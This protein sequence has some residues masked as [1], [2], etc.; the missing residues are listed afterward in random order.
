M[1]TELWDN[2]ALQLDT[3]EET[4]SS[5]G[6]SAALAKIDA[7]I[8]S[9]KASDSLNQKQVDILCLKVITCLERSPYNTRVKSTGFKLISDTLQLKFDT[10]SV[11][12]C[13]FLA[14]SSDL[15]A[16][17]ADEFVL[18]ELS[19][20]IA[21]K[22]SAS[23]NLDSFYTLLVPT[24]VKLSA[25]VFQQFQ[26]GSNHHKKRALA[27]VN[28]LLRSFYTVEADVD[29]TTK[30][31]CNKKLPLAGV[32]S[33]IGSL[34]SL[35]AL[36]TLE[37]VKFFVKDCLVP[38]SGITA[39]S[40]Q[41]L[42]PF[43][44]TLGAAEFTELLAGLQKAALRDS[45][46]VY[47]YVSPA[48]FHAIVGFDVI[49]S[50]VA[51]KFFSPLIAALKSSKDTT[52][53]GAYRT[54]NQ[55]VTKYTPGD[56][57]AAL[58][59]LVDELLKVYKTLSNTA[60]EQKVYITT[61]LR[62]VPDGVLN[63]KIVNALLTAAAK[64][65]HQASLSSNLATLYGRF[66]YDL[67]HDSDGDFTKVK[68][69]TLKGLQDKKQ[70]VRAT[71]CT[72]FYGAMQ[73]SGPYSSKFDPVAEAVT[74][75]TQSI[76]TECIKSP[77]PSVNNKLIT[78]GYAAIAL[79]Y[80]TGKL[81]D[82]IVSSVFE[83][84]IL[85]D[86]SL[87]QKLDSFEWFIYAVE[88]VGSIISEDNIGP[89][90]AAFYAGVSKSIKHSH[91]LAY[92]RLHIAYS[93]NQAHLSGSC[94][95]A[96]NDYIIAPSND[97]VISPH[98]LYAFL[99]SITKPF[100]GSDRSILENTLVGLLLPC[101]HES[102][103]SIP[104]GWVAICQ[105]V[106]VDPGQLISSRSEE[107]VDMLNELLLEKDIDNGVYQAA[108]SAISTISF[109]ASDTAVPRIADTIDT[110]LSS[111]SELDV[112][113]EKCAIWLANEG[114]L[115][116]D[117]LSKGEKPQLSKNSKDYETAKWEQEVRKEIAS[118][119]KST[120]SLTKDEKRM[121]AE[122]LKLETE[123]RAS[124]ESSYRKLSRALNLIIALSNEGAKVDNDAKIWFPVAVRQLLVVLRSHEAK[125]LVGD[126][127]TKC[128]LAMAQVL[129]VT[130]L[131]GTS[132]M[133][134]IGASTLRLHGIEAFL[135][136]KYLSIDLKSL[137]NDQLFSLKIAS[138]KSQFS[139]LTMTYILPLLVKVITNGRDFVSKSKKKVVQLD[140]DYIDESPEEE[141]LAL[142]LSI[143][144]SNYETFEDSSIPRT[145]ILRDIIAL[146][147][148][149]SKAK[150][151]KDAF[152]SLCQS[153]AL[154]ISSADLEEIFNACLDPSDYVRTAA[155]ESLDREFELSEL[156][157]VP[158]IWIATFD[159]KQDNRELAQ[160]IWEESKFALDSSVPDKLISYLSHDSSVTRLSVAQSLGDAMAEL[161]D[162][163]SSVID[164]LLDLYRVKA[165]PPAPLK[166]AFG[167]VIKT[168]V[169]TDYWEER[170]GVALSLKY[171]APQFSSSK[172]VEKVFK[173][174][175]EE[176]ALADKNE[177]VCHELKDAGMEIIN[178]HGNENVEALITILE[179][180]LN[181]KTGNHEVDDRMKESTIV[182]Y[183]NLAH[184]LKKGDPRVENIV[185]KLLDALSTP[186]EDVQFA[187]SERIAPLVPFVESHLA[188]HYDALFEKLF[189][190]KT[191]A[192]RRGAAY[193]IAGLTKG[194][195]LIAMTDYDVVRNLE[196]GSDDRSDPKKREGVMFAIE[197]LS[198][199]LG[200]IFEPYVLELLP[201]VLKSFGDSSAEVREAT[202]YAAKEIM[203]NTTS[204]GIKKLIPMAIEN[205]DD[206]AWRAKKGSVELLGSMA[207]LD[208]AQLS[209]SLPTIVPEIVG[210][211]NDSHREVRKAADQ[212]LKKFGEVI[213]NPEI[214]EI[215]PTLL[216]AIG[217]PTK[218][219]DT[220]L[221][222][223]INTQ[224][225][226][227]IDGPSMALIIHVIDR[228]MHDRSAA[229]KKK[230]CQIVGNMAILVDTKDLLA[231]LPKLITEL[232]K[233]IVDPVPQTRTT[234]SRALG[235]L[236]EKLG[237]EQFPTLIPGLLDTLRDPSRPGDRMGSAQALAEIIKGIGP[238]KLDE[239]L[240]II[241]EGTSSPQSH[242]RAGFLPM[243]IFLPACF[244]I[245]Y[246]PYLSKSI[247]PILG[248][249]ADPYDD[250]R[251]VA[252]K[253]GRLIVNNYANKAID[254]L[255]PELEK[256]MAND[257]PRIRLSSV[258]LTGDLLFKISGISGNV[259]SDEE[260]V[261]VTGATNTFNEV[262][263]EE[264]R[265]QVLASLFICRSDSAG[266]VRVGATNIW[267]A[268]VAN[269]PRT[270]KEVL[271]V[272][273]QLIVRRLASSEEA[274]RTIGAAA[275]G[276]MVRRVGGDA[277]S[278]LLPTLEQS[279]VSSDSDAK[280]GICIALR[281]LIESSEPATI[282]EHKATVVKVV[283]SALTDANPS[284]REAAAQV[285]DV[286][287]TSIGNDAVDD[288]IP[289]L[290]EKLEDGDQSDD[291][292]SAL[293][294][295]MS[296]KADVIF[297]ILI[298]TLLKPPINAHAL[299]ALAQVAGPALYRKLS[300]I[301]GSIVR[302]ILEGG[303]REELLSALTN[304]IL[305]VESD[306]GCHSVML[307]ILAL[308]RNEDDAKV[309]VIYEVLPQ[310]I[311]ESH[312]DYSPYVQD[313]VVQTILA[314]DSDDQ[315]VAKNSLNSLMKL[316]SKLP[317]ESLGQL[318]AP[319]EQTLSMVGQDG[320]EMYAFSLPRGPNAV[321][322]IF[323]HGLMYGDKQQKELSA[324]AISYVVDRT[325]AANLRPFVTLI[326]GPLIR[327]IGERSSGDVKSAI[328]LALDKLF[329]KIPQFLRPFIPQ[330][331]RTFIKSLSDT[332][333]ELLRTR[334]ARALGTLIEY[335]PR[336]DP[337]VTELLN[338]AKTVG[339]E[340][341]G[342][343]TAILKAL[344][345]V[346]DKAGSKMSESSKNGIL[347]LVEQEVFKE[348]VGNDTAVSYAKL[349]GALSSI[350]DED[351]TNRMLKA[352]VLD[353]DMDDS[354]SARF[355]VL[356][357]NAFLKYSPETVLNGGLFEEI[358]QFIVDG[359]QSTSTYVSDNL[360]TAAGKLLLSLD[361][362]DDDEAET[363]SDLISELAVCAMKPN[364]SS[365][366]TRR[367]SLVVFR[368]ISR[369]QYERTVA[370]YLDVLIP[371]VFS[372]VRDAII[373]I[374]L[375]G[376]KSFLA[377]TRLVEDESNETF[378]AWLDTK[379]GETTVTT[380]IGT[381]LQLRSI[382]EYV[383]RVGNR[384]AR[385]E[386]E[387]IAA[388]GDKEAMFSDQYEDE[389]EVW[390]I[391]GV[392]LTPE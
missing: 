255:L 335:Q 47:L 120:K 127:A 29:A 101:H 387:R 146:M 284:V 112:D 63:E 339:K 9:K 25:S 31:I 261:V 351:E 291:A 292:L 346:T 257:N 150:L 324:N 209:S 27:K 117:I 254:L 142:A 61:I 190:G 163:F 206:T 60:A 102:F 337:L 262:L 312:L 197:C 172:E 145:D 252:L 91:I 240:P 8:T 16:A 248:G 344:M 334:A 69:T 361:K 279:L 62:S 30:A 191:F 187:V 281:E 243:L 369:Q 20:L 323:L 272:L 110:D 58:T 95:A 338:G 66:F 106:G 194:K 81:D 216:K 4:T 56:D 343:E 251:D 333:N 73:A 205:L 7:E 135:P 54:L 181:S 276:D 11:R 185:D 21:Q 80:Y 349:I 241:L 139:A 6:I 220:A 148:I 376:E 352:K 23:D 192:Q 304:V 13:K 271:P 118:K 363:I 227:Y 201:I 388:G 237:E 183:G 229:T 230:A 129:S 223:L 17:A 353:A 274:Q 49:S 390:A 288:V 32:V 331:Q 386:K 38:K 178:R 92:E 182:L 222:G 354:N 173:F 98:H 202:A 273:T 144:T 12:I 211:L 18:L 319:A 204:Y 108:C 378:N 33:N 327:A 318:V 65:G 55:L 50:T 71:W 308:M 175:V 234:A 256:G 136:E 231:Y 289:Q 170:S 325:P 391:G 64:D 340:D 180:G 380:A 253:A 356:V 164:K 103:A 290:L 72:S 347:G 26:Q 83:S 162:Q 53:E 79:A 199:S 138:E 372:C 258:E 315:E 87:L 358:S 44:A 383:K 140:D 267:K 317:K 269:T 244:G 169:T 14:H 263:G 303:D 305:S 238:D 2:I 168:D 313:L 350:L 131:H 5:N 277:L 207:F 203:R 341:I 270:V 285:F 125:L 359:L 189:A 156:G 236:V 104:N 228:G 384:L 45:E 128:F 321:L 299:S 116:V 154:N 114:E 213:R 320:D 345:E 188:D 155:L 126:L 208:P 1:A 43:I 245:Q 174:L 89:G 342:V 368:T 46:L 133:D 86:L 196:E 326:V 111:V 10:Y 78:G 88:A 226:H 382:S 364:S 375:A 307:E 74:P 84:K 370:P 379:K 296:K 109:V 193:G 34:A 373:P 100:E 367:L 77:L 82:S 159:A 122:Q 311:E 249:L 151:A 225:V 355:A 171:M 336:V 157:F 232:Q 115:V 198:Q 105:A 239:M 293:K 218:Y 330:L 381:T 246:A 294:E 280:Q 329:I 389:R 3:L 166:D 268:L 210:V 143:I 377:V 76:L 124:V 392:D 212:S 119:K 298:P 184:H 165:K 265:I 97:L 161:S 149:T 283:R 141:Q 70:E 134:W 300:T 96:I 301:V 24:V 264:K 35:K 217:E 297:P 121:V 179:D 75:S 94:V 365:P 152:S 250:I 67:L 68:D 48:V 186:S 41:A 328:L 233:S 362:L 107:I 322:P 371:S 221:D 310:F 19:T 357:L 52:R 332:S 260:P 259:D 15:P 374:K 219:T 275:L 132:S 278:Q 176:K 214:Q 113:E 93:K 215:V 224:F 306:N 316:V 286:L 247:P 360:V 302:A 242:I 282:S 90:Y 59:K 36:N 137:V 295:I 123:I 348:D 22:L 42:E 51:S 37:T 40:T 85:T 314:L 158:Q 200:P 385:V 39:E 160:T 57:E 366:D 266:G 147:A 153:I 130:G 167:L 235:S 177:Q 287:Q 28:R 195:G 309:K 99:M